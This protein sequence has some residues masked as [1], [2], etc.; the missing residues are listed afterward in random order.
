MPKINCLRQTI[1]SGSNEFPLYIGFLPAKDILLVAEA[2]S[3]SRTTAHRE[4]ANNILS[5]PIGDWQRPIENERVR[6]ISDLYDNTGEFMP[7]PVLLC[8][9]VINNHKVIGYDQQKAAGGI[10]TNVWEIT[11]PEPTAGSHKPLW[12]LDGQHRINGLANSAQSDNVIPVVLLLNEGLNPYSGPLLAKL[13]AQVTTSATKLDELHNEWLTF[14]FNLDRYD[15]KLG[16]SASEH[17]QAME[18]VAELCR[19]PLVLPSSVN[20]PLFNEIK[21]NI[22]VSVN[23]RPGGFTFSCI[24]W[25]DLFRANYYSNSAAIGSHLAPKALAQ[26]IGLAFMALTQ[27]VTAPLNESVFF[28]TGE[29]GQEIMQ[30][31]FV[32]GVL[33]YLLEH[34]PPSSWVDVLNNLSFKTTDWNFKSWVRTLSGP[35][36]TTSKNLAA[37]VFRKVFQERSLP[38]GPG[39][40]RDFLH[41]NNAKITMLFSHIDPGKSRPSRRNV[42]TLEVPRGA[43]LSESIAPRKHVKISFKSENIGKL[44]VTDKS[45]PPGRIV[46]YRLIGSGIQIDPGKHSNPLQLL[47]R[48]EHYGGIESTADLSISW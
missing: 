16:A 23:P 39:N 29:Y 31:A 17:K 7:N 27:V 6:S 47:I 22:H 43:V 8:E 44:T 32:I 40:L 3:F 13:F 18:A 42:K 14:A 20:N 9:N 30:D 19:T 46:E 21:F 26:Q 35:A 25:K 24:D 28:G 45:S 2:P 33:S 5:P 38:T 36:Q 10:P 11:L 1:K 41:G 34:G 37:S 4:I 15:P 48:M 12:I